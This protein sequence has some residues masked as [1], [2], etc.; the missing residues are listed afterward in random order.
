MSNK[1]FQ[2]IFHYF[3]CFLNSK[4]DILSPKVSFKGCDCWKNLLLISKNKNP[5]HGTTTDQKRDHRN[6]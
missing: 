2:D 1:A 3:V 5:T 4:R 6:W